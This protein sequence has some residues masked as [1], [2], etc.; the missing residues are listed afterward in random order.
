MTNSLTNR[1]YLKHCLIILHII[2]CTS[3]KSHFDE[4]NLY[5]MNFRFIDVKIQEGDETHMLLYSLPLLYNF[6]ETFQFCK[7]IIFVKEVKMA[8]LSKK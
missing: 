2:E 5:L 8:L 1:L 4:F 3:I 7:D 6:K